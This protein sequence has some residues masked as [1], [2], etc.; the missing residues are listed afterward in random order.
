MTEEYGRC[1]LKTGHPCV[2]DAGSICF[3]HNNREGKGKVIAMND[4]K[5]FK[6]TKKSCSKAISWALSASML[7]GSCFTANAAQPEQNLLSVSQ[8]DAALQ[9]ESAGVSGGDLLTVSGN[10]LSVS[11]GDLFAARKTGSWQ[12]FNQPQEIANLD[13]GTE[14]TNETIFNPDSET[15][16]GFSDIEF[17]E[18][19]KDWVGGVYYPREASKKE[20]GASYVENGEGYLAISSQV[21]KETE[22]TGYGV[23]TYENTSTFDMVLA[24][25]DYQVDVTFVNPTD[26]A[27]T[28]YVEAEDITKAGDIKVDPNAEVTKSFTAVLVDGILNL[29]FPVN[30]SATTLEQAAV[31]KAYVSNVTIT[32]LATEQK[33]DKPTLYLAS[34][35]TVQTY[36]KGEYPKTGWGQTLAEFF[37]DTVKEEKAEDCTYG[38]SRRYVTEN[39]VVENRAIGGRSSKSFVEEGKLDDLLEDIKVGD[40]LFIQ[41]GHNDATAVRP[42]RYVSPENFAQ[43][44]LYYVDGARQ[45]GAVP[46]LVTPVARYSQKD[47]IFNISFG[48][49]RDVMFKLAEEQGVAIVDLGKAS[50]DLCTSFGAEGAKSFFMKLAAGEYENY[51]GG[52]NDDTHLQYYGAYKFAQCVAKGIQE[53]E[54]A[55]LK[56]LAP[57][58]KMNI[59]ENAPGKIV[60]LKVTSAGSSSISIAWDKDENAEMYYIYR[61][62]LAEGEKA[63]DIVL[64]E[65]D[66]YSATSLNKYTD[67]NCEEGKTY[68]YAVKGF[69]EKGTS[70]AMSEYLVVSTKEAGIRIDFNYGN[71]ATMKGWTP[72]NE[73][74]MYGKQQGEQSY[75]WITSPGGGRDRSQGNDMERDFIMGEGEFAYDLPNGD[76][77][78]TIYSGDITG[79]SQKTNFAGEGLSIGTASSKKSVA[80]VTGTVRVEDGQMNITITKGNGYGYTNGMTV[81]ELLLA[82]GGV[83]AQEIIVGETS[84]TF[85][86]FFGDVEGAVSY[87][88]YMKNST[89][90][91]FSVAKT[92]NAEDLSNPDGSDVA[93]RTIPGDTGEVYECYVTAVMA[94]GS[95]SA[96]SDVITVELVEKGP[97]APAPQNLICKSPSKESTVLQREIT[98]GWDEVK[99]AIKYVIYRNDKVEGDKAYDPEAFVKIG[100]S[101]TTEFTDTKDITTNIPYSYKVA[102]FTKTGIGELSEVCVSNVSGTLVPGGREKY[103]DR[104]LVAINLAGDDGGMQVTA[105]DKDGNELT[106]GVYLSWRSYEADMNGANELNTT[107]TVKRN[108]TV[109]AQDV[110]ITNLVDEGGTASDTY[111]VEG[112][113]DNA[114]GVHS[115]ETK[116]W[117]NKYLEL[118]LYAPADETMPDASVCNYHA[119]DMSVGDLDGDGDLELIVK[120]YPSNAKDNS[121]SGFTGKTFLDGYDVDFATGKTELL[122]RIDLGVNIRSGAHYTQ[123]QVWDYDGDK[124]AEIAMKTADGTTTYKTTDG[125]VNTLTKNGYVGACDTDALPVETT[126]AEHDYRNGSGYILEGPEYLT[127]FNGEDGSILDTADYLPARGNVSAWGDGWGNRVDRFLSATAYLDGETPFAVFARGYYTRTCLTAYYMKDT[128][129]DGFGDMLDVYWEFDT[130]KAGTQYE[131]QGNHGL[132]VNDVDNDGKDEIIYG[133]LVVDHNGTVKYSTG[134]GHG[135]AMHISDWVSWNDGLEIMSVHEHGNAT[136]HVEV[137]D[138]E[139]GKI[140]MG[141]NTGKDTGRGVAADIDPTAEGGEWWSIAS[142]TYE[143]NDEPSWDSTNG[144][145]Y[146]S[147]STLDKLIKLSDST[148]ASNASIFWDG[149]LLSEVQDHKFNEK[150]GYVPVAMAI[151][152]WNYEEQKQEE[153]LYSE[154]VWSNNGTKGNTGLTADILGDWREEI[155][156]RSSTDKNKVRV[157]STTI[158]TDY[159][160]PCLLE[161]LAYREAVAWQ[162]VGYNQPANTSYLLSEGLV[163][164]QLSEGKVTGNSAEVLFTPAND[165]NLYGH[166]ITAYEIYRAEGDGAYTKIDTVD[167]NTLKPGQGSGEGGTEEQPAMDVKYENDFEDGTSDFKILRA[168]NEVI[169]A[170]TATQNSNASNF[171]FSMKGAARGE[172]GAMS[173]EIQNCSEDNVLVNLDLRLEAAAATK[174]TVVALIGSGNKNNWLDA[175]AQILKIV[176]KV[177]ADNGFFESVTINGTDITAKANVSNGKANAESSGL[178]GLNR[179]TTGWLHLEAKLN[180]T[181]QKA[182][183]VLTR[184]SD[185]STVYEGTLDFVTPSESLKHIFMA[186]GKQ[187]GVA[188]LDNIVVGKENAPAEKPEQPEEKDVYSYTDNTVN[189][190]TQY[191]YK[192]AAVVDGKTSHM[193]RPVSIKTAIQIQEV[194]AIVLDNLVEGTPIPEG[195]T[196]A[197]LLPKTVKVIDEDKQEQNAEV[198]WDVTGVDINQAGDYKVYASIK[199]YEQKIE[200]ALKV[201]PNAVKGVRNP[202]DIT[203]IV[204]TKA[205]LPETVTV[206]YTNTTTEEK[207]VTWDTSSLK[208]DTVGD[209]T[210]TGTVEGIEQKATVVVKV[211]ENY[212]TV[213]DKVY[214]EIDL[215]ADAAAA[216]PKKVMAQFAD[217]TRAEAAV[218]W[219]LEGVDT[220]KPGTVEVTGTVADFDGEV[221]A[222]V[223]IAY[224]LVARFDFGIESNRSAEGWTTITVN[225]KKGTNTAAK[226]GVAYTP[227]KG[228]GFENADAVIEGRT[229]EFTQEGVL[230]VN[231]Y[232]D[233]ALPQGQT[234]LLDVKN[235]TYEVEMIGA[236]GLKGGTGSYAE[237]EG[238]TLNVDHKAPSYASGKQIVEVKDGQLTVKFSS[239]KLSRTGALVV[240]SVTEEPEKPEVVNKEA[241]K[242][243]IEQAN[244]IDLSKYT[245]ESAAAL[246]AAKEAAAAVLADENATQEAVNTAVEALNRAIAELKPAEP[247]KPE[248]P[249]DAAREELKEAVEKAFGIDLSS[250]TEE[251]IAAFMAARNAAE[252]VL[253]DENATKEEINAAIE[254]LNQ[255][256][257]ALTP[258]QG[259]QGGDGDSGNNGDGGNGGSGDNGGNGNGGAGDQSGNDAG[260]ESDEKADAPQTTNAVK[261]GDQGSG[262]ALGIFFAV[263]AV[264]AVAGCLKWRRKQRG[265]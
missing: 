255:A 24:N 166:D 62:V 228:Y 73:K 150:Q 78:V 5:K 189:S 245:E 15:A 105:T 183:V 12:D 101:K 244:G 13:F 235:G 109:I 116:V 97:K 198:T 241:L 214:V 42:N 95:E 55:D 53:S 220:S 264:L 236:C 61:H 133:A 243:A 163:T 165:G 232:T 111:T 260:S 164:A 19:A 17:K 137:R 210:L 59:P 261:T 110:K 180:F 231:V 66:R 140:L 43:W 176:G 149:D 56:A 134:L 168:D 60:N 162:N 20:P 253:A 141:Y 254:A 217:G 171:V 90:D 216:M 172:S 76:Y 230:P 239:S 196:V 114:I 160:V 16:M 28:A 257:A 161:N 30:S 195:K 121:G 265:E 41:W 79:S 46:V 209:Y 108:G 251:S 40:Y 173:P 250:Y 84:S 199:G 125:T 27:Y 52:S 8:G 58:V 238:V 63:E 227:E 219:N 233:F 37:G 47:G 146:S 50:T 153:L 44:I 229:E 147:W 246:T 67:S 31:Q 107:F 23:Y 247:Q 207:N 156:V 26:A 170:D 11:G 186:G 119:N 128:N 154:E 181:Q 169:G 258:D 6:L 178:G 68:I 203:I 205:P 187:Y 83:Y 86:I 222:V 159:V 87:N 32:R 35:S 143:G 188:S 221:T 263:A 174:E 223:T 29:K 224:P 85:Q 145:V 96:R 200:V 211:K 240:R 248:T 157:Y 123:F 9:D 75:G 151:Y 7:V 175:E 225:K 10:L 130:N 25:A 193:S 49:Y 71:S 237:I 158:Q 208:E 135:D 142:P 21:W 131:A 48:A 94:D 88:V 51:P 179:D 218:T 74:T 256:I 39:V 2:W 120:W 126:D 204:G 215:N 202:D 98:M 34:D 213:V 234:F 118:N 136:Y 81:T 38:Q 113:N 3:L 148:P 115:V 45:R 191:S 93:V 36:E 106:K 117:N 144:E 72:V 184:I 122:W 259:G 206:E 103:T 127:M 177:G 194:P 226:L 252:A 82:P 201:V 100:E 91:S 4:K 190:N 80:S 1:S 18:P 129:N 192:I 249:E 138:A 14:V 197:D 33:E 112:S 22:K 69:N 185:G 104:A 70:E 155:I 242:T 89:D 132:G 92:I 102:A 77:E 99:G 182:E 167:V 64:T 152:K 65:D 212:V 139:T 57:L 124:K 262:W 54:N